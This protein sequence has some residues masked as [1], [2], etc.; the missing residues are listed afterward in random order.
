MSSTVC[1]LHNCVDPLL[2]TDAV[3]PSRNAASSIPAV[4]TEYGVVHDASGSALVRIGWTE[5]VCSI[6]GPRVESSGGS[7]FSDVGRIE[8]DVK[9]SSFATP[10]ANRGL[11]PPETESFL[12]E[13]LQEALNTTV[14]REKYPKCTISVY[15]VIT[16]ACGNELSAA[17]AASSLALVDAAIEVID[18][19]A[20]CNVVIREDLM[21]INPAV[22]KKNVSEASLTVSYSPSFDS[23]P[24]VFWKGRIDMSKMN[25]VFEIAK[26]GSM[27]MRQEL[28]ASIRKRVLAATKY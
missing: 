16:Q 24:H 21:Q 2:D 19:I 26:Q 8:V 22:S 6:F 3:L 15:V 10:P 27:L 11:T 9:Y 17:L 14:C 25:E 7:S 4:I 5:A 13:R 28:S 20:P 1:S 12:A 18:I 23:Y